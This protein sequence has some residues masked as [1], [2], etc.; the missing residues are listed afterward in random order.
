M[1][2]GAEC[3]FCNLSKGRTWLE[4]GGVVAIL[5]GFP[6]SEGHT[7][8]IPRRHVVA[9]F[10]LPEAELLHLWVVVA[11]VRK[12]LQ[13]KYQPDAFN[14]GIN[15]G[16]AAGQTVGHAH[17]HIIPRR[18]GDVVDPRGGIRWVIPKKAKYW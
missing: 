8:V 10:D 6:L 17:V 2:S 3:P 13:K 14:I 5:D 1:P 7:L 12:I 15:E 9:L 18:K 16:E 4:I 11:K